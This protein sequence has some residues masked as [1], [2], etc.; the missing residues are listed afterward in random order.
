M[1]AVNF[2]YNRS[3]NYRLVQDQI[4]KLIEDQLVGT[5]VTRS[6]EEARRDALN[7]G[8]HI[9]RSRTDNVPMP[10]DVLM[11]HGLADKSY[12]LASGADGRRL[13]N[14]Y[15]HVIVSGEWFRRRLRHWRWHPVPRRRVLI[16]PSRVHIGGWPRSDDVF[17]SR[18][19]EMRDGP[20]RLLWAPSH[21]TSTREQSFS[22][23]PAFETHLER[24]SQEFDVRVSLHPSNRTDKSP[25][26]GDLRWA[27]VV[28]SDFGTLLYEAWAADKCVIIP[29][30]LIPSEISTGSQRFSAEGYVY[31]KRIGH[32]AGSLEEL[33]A[34]ARAGS[35]PDARVRKLMS[36]VLEPRYRGTSARRIAQLLRSLPIR[37]LEQPGQ[38]LIVPAGDQ[39]AA[40][41]P[42]PAPPT[43]HHRTGESAGG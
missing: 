7:F 21:D 25:T 10:L 23:Y 15:E 14:S 19:G 1:R 41:A 29:N 42:R 37:R 30:W 39:R 31:R 38:P 12:L 16:P 40:S 26:H 13:I 11:S 8:L 27:D 4:F 43:S 6:T 3:P 9:R 2:V 35:K 18:G 34:I 24:L 20:R 36:Q 33:I 5:E 17:D 32:H 22:S 28:V